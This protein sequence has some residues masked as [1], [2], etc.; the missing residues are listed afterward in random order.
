MP[1]T[2][3]WAALL[4]IAP[5][6]SIL[7]ALP[8]ATMPFY[9]DERG[10]NPLMVLLAAPVYLG[11]VAAPGYLFAATSDT[12]AAELSSGRRLWVRASLVLAN[13]SAAGGVIGGSMMFLFLPPSLVSLC[14]AACVFWRFERRRAPAQPQTTPP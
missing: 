2:G 14:C 8:I 12:R 11:L 1:R 4:C 7:I 6:L 13:L 3:T 9:P 5:I 10:T